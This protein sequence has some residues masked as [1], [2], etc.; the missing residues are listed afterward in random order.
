MLG[1]SMEHGLHN[2]RKPASRG[3]GGSGPARRHNKTQV[4]IEVMNLKRRLRQRQEELVAKDAAYMAMH[5]EYP[6][7]VGD[8][9]Q[10]ALAAKPKNVYAFARNHF[11]AIRATLCAGDAFYQNAEEAPAPDDEP[12]DEPDEEVK[13]APLIT[14]ARILLGAE[15]REWFEYGPDAATSF[16][17]ISEAASRCEHGLAVVPVVTHPVYDHAVTYAGIPD[18][19]DQIATYVNHHPDLAAP[20]APPNAA[21]PK[22]RAPRESQARCVRA[23]IASAPR[24]SSEAR[25][26]AQSADRI[27]LRLDGL[28]MYAP[29]MSLVIFMHDTAAYRQRAFY[30]F[31][32]SMSS[33][34]VTILVVRLS[35]FPGRL[36]ELVVL[37]GLGTVGCWH[38]DVGHLLEAATPIFTDPKGSDTGQAALAGPHH[39]SLA[40]LC[41]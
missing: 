19:V 9:L 23:S 13:A 30:A 20:R 1:A 5:P 18:A 33:F 38:R 6:E 24:N 31:L 37:C 4:E 14:N 35:N 32:A 11:D 10:A 7:M 34:S 25:K 26:E 21:P 17:A 39:V 12:D 27:A 16:A 29:I 2:A 15:K 36:G 28:E 22:P 41:R 8:F 3:G 40:A